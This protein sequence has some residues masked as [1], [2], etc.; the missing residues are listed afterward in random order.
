M[1]GIKTDDYRTAYDLPFDHY[2]KCTQPARKYGVIQIGFALFEKREEE[3]W[4]CRPY[5]FITFPRP[6]K[7]KYTRD[8]A[9]DP[10]CVDFHLKVGTD[11]QRWITKGVSYFDTFNI[12][13]LE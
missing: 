10:D 3:G 7:A 2:S 6:Y 13:K 5:N 4:T 8:V 11:F 1:S 12:E 9:L